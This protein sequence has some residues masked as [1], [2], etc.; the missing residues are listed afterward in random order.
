MNQVFRALADETRRQIVALAWEEDRSA[1]ELAAHFAMSRPG[2]SQHLKVLL[3]AGVVT[4]RHAGTRRY[5]R[6]SQDA[7]RQA[8]DLIEDFWRDSLHRLKAVAEAAEREG[9]K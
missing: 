4:V 6:T 1:G 9:S 7:L 2:V 3:E 8:R 5:Y